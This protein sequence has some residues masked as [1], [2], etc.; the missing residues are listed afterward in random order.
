MAR[1]LDVFWTEAGGSHE[2]FRAEGRR[3]LTQML[4]V[5]PQPQGQKERKAEAGS[6][7]KRQRHCSRWEMMGA[8]TTWVP[9]GVISAY[10]L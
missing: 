3:D 10:T 5:F 4:S 1:T 9:G 6:L 8:V 2:G 7:R